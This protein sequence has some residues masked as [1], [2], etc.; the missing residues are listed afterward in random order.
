MIADNYGHWPAGIP[1]ANIAAWQETVANWRAGPPVRLVI[2][3]EGKG[4]HHTVGAVILNGHYLAWG[5]WAPVGPRIDPWLRPGEENEVELYGGFHSR[6]D[7]F[8][9]LIRGVRLEAFPAVGVE[10]FFTPAEKPPASR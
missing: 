7:A 4:P 10:A 1:L 8:Q 6:G 3:H 5:D 9:T 2:E